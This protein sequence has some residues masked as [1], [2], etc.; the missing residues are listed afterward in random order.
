MDALL[1]LHFATK[2]VQR[3]LTLTEGNRVRMHQLQRVAPALDDVDRGFVGVVVHGQCA[4]DSDLLGHDFVGIELWHLAVLEPSKNDGA[5]PRDDLDG[6]ADGRG[7]A[8]CDLHDHVGALAIADLLHGIDD[9]RR[10]HVDRVIGAKLLRDFELE[11]IRGKPGHDHRAGSRLPRS[12]DGGQAALPTAKHH[13]RVADARTRD[14]VRPAHAGPQRVEHH[15][16]L[17]RSVGGDAVQQGV[18]VEVH[19]LGVPAP[20]RRRFIDCRGFRCG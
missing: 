7:R 18:G 20:K 16:E 4:L 15:R 12:D 19:V 10:V 8:A 13:D 14:A 3:S 17:R 2:E 1:A 5:P 6:I 11:F 9:A